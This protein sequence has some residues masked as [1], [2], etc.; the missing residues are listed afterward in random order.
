MVLTLLGS[1]LV[2]VADIIAKGGLLISGSTIAYDRPAPLWTNLMYF[3]G[4]GVIHVTGDGL[5]VSHQCLQCT[6][7]ANEH[8]CRPGGVTFSGEE[9]LACWD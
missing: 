6:S 8:V 7:D 2:A 9:T 3:L 1:S 4:F 5:L